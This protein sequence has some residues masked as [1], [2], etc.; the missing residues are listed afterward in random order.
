MVNRDPLISIG[1]PAYNSAAHIG[2][3]L[4]SLLGQTFGDFELIVSDNASADETREAVEDYRRKDSRI[5]YE[6]QPVNV[7]AN[8]NYSLVAQRARGKLFKWTSSSDWCAPVFLERCLQLLRAHPDTVL[9]A[10][11]TRLFERTPD[12]SRPYDGDIEVL[13]DTPSA[14]FR[15]V[16][17]TMAL[18]NAFNGLIRMHALRRTRLVRAYRGSD[19]ILMGHLALLGKFRLIDE[20]LYYRRMERSSSTALQDES[21][22]WKH[23]YPQPTVHMLMQGTKRHLDAFRIVVSTPMPHAERLRALAIAARMCRWNRRFLTEDLSQA[24]RYVSRRS[25]PGQTD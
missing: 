18:N 22:V 23:H 5:R 11:R 25:L 9:A 7:G 14:R 3:A 17:S 15:T 16:M 21:D 1:M 12:N 4:E 24:W 2:V 19:V 8:R 10:P 6:R 20:G 13:D